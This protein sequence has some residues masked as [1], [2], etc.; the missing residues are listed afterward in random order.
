MKKS[1]VF[2][3]QR[4]FNEG[5]EDAQDDAR[6]GQPEMQRTD[7]NV[8]RV[9]T[10]VCSDR[11]LICETN[12]RRIEY[13]NLFRGKDLNSGLTSGFFTMTVPLHMMC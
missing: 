13:G 3:W 11:G 12:N 6:I 5:Q 8:N 2:E 4:R 1:I 7:A 9:Q 10:L